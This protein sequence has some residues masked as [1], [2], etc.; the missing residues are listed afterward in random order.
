MPRGALAPMWQVGFSVSLPIYARTK[1][2]R[3]IAENEALGRGGERTLEN[4]RQ[5]LAQQTQTRLDQLTAAKEIISIYREGLLTQSEATVQSAIAQYQVGRASF[6]SVLEA[7]TGYVSD[8]DRY[9]N[10]L[11]QAQGLSIA[12]QEV[13]LGPTPGIGGGASA[14]AGAMSGGASAGSRSL[15][16]SASASS[17]KSGSTALTAQSGM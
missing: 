13:N 15:A 14:V 8:R 5:I 9:L 6:A 1:Q 12:L 2:Q 3:A 11:A 16:R 10:A 4:L 17:S 7:L